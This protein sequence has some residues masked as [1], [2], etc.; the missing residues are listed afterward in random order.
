ME[1]PITSKPRVICNEDS[2]S[3]NNQKSLFRNTLQQLSPKPPSNS[4]PANIEVAVIDA[5]RIVRIIPITKLKPATFKTWAV[6]VFKHLKPLPGTVLH[7]V[8]DNYEYKFQVP[9]KD[10]AV[11]V[12]RMLS[13]IDQQ[14]PHENE[15][16][17]F[18]DNSKNKSQLINLLVDYVLGD[19][20]QMN[21]EI[22]VNNGDVIIR[23]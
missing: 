17:D 23:S 20:F 5:M 16:K 15:W 22:Y 6:E 19:D 9:S 1:W 10:R 7:I 2:K 11:G 18:L 12:S 3:R 21:K 8:F 13:D 14:L 4:I